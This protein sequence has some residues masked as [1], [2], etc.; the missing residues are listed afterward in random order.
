MDKLTRHGPRLFALCILGFGILN[1]VFAHSFYSGLG[2]QPHINVIPWL[3]AEPWQA[4]ATGVLFLALAAALLARPHARTP[5]L[6]TGIVFLI[7]SLHIAFAFALADPRSISI[8]T[9]V[10]EPLAIGAAALVL[11]GQ[12]R[13][14][15]APKSPA[16]HAPTPA[17]QTVGRILFGLSLIVF[18]VDHLLIPRIIASLIL[19]WVPFRLFLAWFTGFALIAVG[20]A[21]AT[22]WMGRLAA[23]LIG[24]MFLV[25]VVTLHAPRTFG[26]A[27]AG[28]GPRAPAEWSS[29]L[30]ALAMCAASWICSHSIPAKAR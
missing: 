8:R 14:G 27:K 9:I 20:F 25:W 16:A 2:S 1:I 17:L 21:I 12:A 19:P 23:F 5:P 15:L 18:G 29:L 6:L 3:R 22:R 24:I 11:T 7:A 4:Y 13:A 26:L 10:F 30:I 28:S